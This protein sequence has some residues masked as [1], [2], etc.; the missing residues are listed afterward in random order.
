ME[1]YIIKSLMEDVTVTKAM[2]NYTSRKPLIVEMP[3]EYQKN[4]TFSIPLALEY[5]PLAQLNSISI[6]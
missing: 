2:F 3:M 4:H 1:L 6:I 5:I